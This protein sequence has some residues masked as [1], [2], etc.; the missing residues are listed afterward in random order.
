[1]KFKKNKNTNNFNDMSYGGNPYTNDFS[2]GQF[3][4]NPVKTPTSDKINLSILLATL[5]GGAVVQLISRPIYNNAINSIPRPVLIGL[6]FLILSIVLTALIFFLRPTEVRFSG[7]KPLGASRGGVIVVLILA[8]FLLAMLF[9]FLYSLGISGDNE[10]PTSCIFVIDNSGSMEDSDPEQE[11]FRAVDA[12]I[13]NKEDSFPYMIYGFADDVVV[14]RE[15]GPKSAGH[16]DLTTVPEGGTSIKK[17]LEQILD[18]Y[19]TGKWDGGDRPRVVMLTD[20]YATD[21]GFL[22]NMRKV[23]KNYQKNRISVSTVGLGAVDE[24]LM[25]QIA[26]STGGVFISVDNASDLLDAMSN[27]AIRQSKR[28]LL[29][30]R[31]YCRPEALYVI[32]RIVFLAILGMLIGALATVVYGDEYSVM[33]SLIVSAITSVLGAMIMEIGTYAMAL[34]PALM[35]LIMWMLFAATLTLKHQRIIVHESGGFSGFDNSTFNDS[36]SN[37]TDDGTNYWSF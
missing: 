24:D 4:T 30:A 18:D 23:L 5:I 26:S 16:G 25:E 27:A 22:S 32:M 33:V 15:M 8:I 1:M 36:S 34:N 9:Q 3:G 21:I 17:S 28:D 19:S 31:G 37:M 7:Y 12:I 2:K 20:G 11:R 10:E 35:W 6:M 13:A 29:S 14:L